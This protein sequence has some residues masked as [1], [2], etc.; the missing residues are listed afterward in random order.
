MAIS[1]LVTTYWMHILFILSQQDNSF[2]LSSEEKREKEWVR[3]VKTEA[4]REEKDMRIV[5]QALGFRMAEVGC[6]LRNCSSVCAHQQSYQHVARNVRAV[7][8]PK[9]AFLLCRLASRHISDDDLARRD[10]EFFISNIVLFLS[11]WFFVV[12]FLFL[13]KKACQA[14]TFHYF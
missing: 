5:L 11:F 10:D 7:T 6:I 13:S 14:T 2:V 3:K 12:V 8:V 9:C 4:Y 1:T